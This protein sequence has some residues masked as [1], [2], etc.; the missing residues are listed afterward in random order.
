MNLKTQK[1]RINDVFYSKYTEFKSLSNEE[2]KWAAQVGIISF[3]FF[4]KL[5]N[6]LSL[7]YSFIYF[8]LLKHLAEVYPSLVR[9]SK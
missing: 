5:C 6:T 9:Y 7:I 2:K 1:K 3:L 4:S 8:T